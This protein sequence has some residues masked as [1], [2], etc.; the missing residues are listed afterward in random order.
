MTITPAPKPPTQF[1]NNNR[2]KIY[3]IIIKMSSVDE[4]Q[5]IYRLNLYLKK[6][7]VTIE[8]KIN[9]WIISLIKSVVCPYSKIIKIIKEIEKTK[10][11]HKYFIF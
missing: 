7:S 1:A 6:I 3:S 11:V 5:K 4:N 2:L 9:G 10:T 8:A